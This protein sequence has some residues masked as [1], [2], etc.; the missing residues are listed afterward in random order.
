V[1]SYLICYTVFVLFPTEGPSYTIANQHTLCV[2]GA[3]PFHWI[4]RLIQQNAGVHGNAFP[5]AHVAGSV[6]AL[7]FACR[8]TRKLGFLLTPLVILCLG[9]VYDRYHYLADV[10]AG[11]VVGAIPAAWEIARSDLWPRFHHHVT[12]QGRVKLSYCI[13]FMMKRLIGELAA[14]GVIMA[15]LC[16]LACR[17]QRTTFISASFARTFLVGTKSLLAPLRG[18]GSYAITHRQLHSQFQLGQQLVKWRT[19]L[20][21]QSCVTWRDRKTISQKPL[22]SYRV[23]VLF[24]CFCRPAFLP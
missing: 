24:R 8:H 9:A 2:P 14:L 4:V 5:R 16:C 1:L 11:L 23:G 13:P 6:V 17:S 21:I 22:L 3:G 18:R 15:M 10:I 12:I 7:I 20:L 19:F